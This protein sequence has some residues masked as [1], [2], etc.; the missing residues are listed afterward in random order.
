MGSKTTKWAQ[1][2]T[3]A[4]TTFGIHSTQRAESM[5]SS[6]SQFCKKT[7]LATD[8]IKD[9]DAMS[10]NQLLLSYIL[11]PSHQS[12]CKRCARKKLF[13]GCLPRSTAVRST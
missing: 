10:D 11:P 4:H 12:V 1:C 2:H 13:F 6:V 5:N 9:L 7:S 8:L 3:W